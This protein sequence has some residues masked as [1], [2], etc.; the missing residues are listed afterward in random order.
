MER[1]TDKDGTR[2][3]DRT[4]K[5]FLPN[6]PTF[7]SATMQ[8]PEMEALLRMCELFSVSVFSAV[9]GIFK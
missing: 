9:E 8:Y 3:G 2:W 5:I 7:L 6:V 4:Q 1:A